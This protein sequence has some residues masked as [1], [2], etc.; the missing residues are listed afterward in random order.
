MI[1]GAEIVAGD[2]FAEQHF[3]LTAGHRGDEPTVAE[4]VG[5]SAGVLAH[6]GEVGIGGASESVAGAVGGVDVEQLI[7][8]FDVEWPEQRGIDEAEHGAGR[9]DRQA[10]C[11][12]DDGA[13]ERPLGDAARRET[14]GG[15]D[16]HDRPGG[17]GPRWSS[18]YERVV[19]VFRLGEESRASSLT[20]K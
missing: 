7:R 18:I 17:E 11:D 20:D 5:D 3:G 6:V 9:A 16:V 15:S 19:T 13:E 1:G 2:D 10:E 14:E 4:D 12:D 8:L